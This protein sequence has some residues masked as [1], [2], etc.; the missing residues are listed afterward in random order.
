MALKLLVTREGSPIQL[1]FEVEAIAAN[2]L[3]TILE[4]PDLETVRERRTGGELDSHL[5][6]IIARHLRDSIDAAHETSTIKPTCQTE[7]DG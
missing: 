2:I 7:D 3:E 1:R 5:A 6:E 4:A